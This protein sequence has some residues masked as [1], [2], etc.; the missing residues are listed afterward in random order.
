ML[1]NIHMYLF[2]GRLQSENNKERQ[3]FLTL[4]LISEIYKWKLMDQIIR[5]FSIYVRVKHIMHSPDTTIP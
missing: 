4:K 3:T 5:N 2:V 1:L